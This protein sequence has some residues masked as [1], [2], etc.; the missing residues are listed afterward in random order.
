MTREREYFFGEDRMGRG[1]FGGRPA[2]K[3]GPRGP[4]GF[5]HKSQIVK[6]LKENMQSGHKTGLNQKILD[7][8]APRPPLLHGT[9]LKKKK[10]PVPFTG[11]AAFVDKFAGPQ[12][13][14]EVKDSGKIRLYK[15]PELALQC[16]L[17]TETQQEKALRLLDWKR[18]EAVKQVADAARGWDPH[19]D[20]KAE[21]DPF[22]TI[23]VAKLSFEVTEK[24]LRREFEEFGPIRR[25]RI[26]LDKA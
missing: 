23:F 11:L 4:G 18:E 26:V 5:V 20:L 7:Y 14:E 21:G 16:R 6:Q 22:R 3:G 9:E 24:K 13:P 25:V 19:K 12:D 17:N 15:N 10:L 1:G 8:F 2:D